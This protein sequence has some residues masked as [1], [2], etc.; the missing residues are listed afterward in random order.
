MESFVLNNLKKE[1]AE[2]HEYRKSVANNV[3]KLESFIFNALAK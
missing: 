3:A 1:L 2:Q